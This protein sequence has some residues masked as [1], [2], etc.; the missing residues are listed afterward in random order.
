MIATEVS[1]LATHNT[2]HSQHES[3]TELDI[4]LQR[5]LLFENT[6]TKNVSRAEHS[7]VPLE[8]A[9]AELVHAREFNEQTQAK[10]TKD[11]YF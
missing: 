5:S 4:N 10:F 9:T 11:Q 7:I 1:F 6:K 2:R 8:R 3:T